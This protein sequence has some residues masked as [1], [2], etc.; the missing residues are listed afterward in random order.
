MRKIVAIAIVAIII[1][2]SFSCN[3]GSSKKQLVTFK[4]TATYA[5]GVLIAKG[6]KEQEML[7]MDLDLI[8]QGMEDVLADKNDTMEKRTARLFIN[9]YGEEHMEE[10]N[11]KKFA[12]NIEAG[13]K[14][15]EKNGKR[16]GVVTTESGLQYEVI[17]Q[18][19][20]PIPTEEDVVRVHYT[21][22]LVDGSLFE[23]SRDGDPAIFGV[24]QVIT[25]W[26]EAL[27]MMNVGS[28][29]K[30]SLPQDL[31]YGTMVRPGGK[32]EPYSTLIFEVE[33]LGIEE[34][35]E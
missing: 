35:P 2:S 27:L 32:I 22:W 8:L 17:K 18:G 12:E 23:S 1:A 29:Y 21:G 28:I 3:T 26:T 11:R 10:V 19:E 24:T 5:Y 9:L 30:I 25:G 13:E 34:R 20:G 4:D 33:L 15:L 14:H 31:A 7:D 16:K 6:L